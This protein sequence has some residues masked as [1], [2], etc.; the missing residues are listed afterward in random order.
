M[1]L[2]FSYTSGREWGLDD[3]ILIAEGSRETGGEELER[4]SIDTSVQVYTESTAE[5]WGRAGEEEGQGN[6]FG[7]RNRAYPVLFKIPVLRSQ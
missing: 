5:T 6:S 3:I 2:G 1:T 4:T 7:W